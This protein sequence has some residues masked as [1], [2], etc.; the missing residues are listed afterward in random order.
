MVFRRADHEEKESNDNNRSVG[1]MAAKIQKNPKAEKQTIMA[2]GEPA[3][4]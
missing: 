4:K 2:A 1:I 3:L